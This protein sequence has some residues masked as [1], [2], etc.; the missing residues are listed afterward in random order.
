M[1]QIVFCEASSIQR[2][3]EAVLLN[4]IRNQLD[5]NVEVEKNFID[6]VEGD[7][8]ESSNVE[9]GIDVLACIMAFRKL[10]NHPSLLLDSLNK[11]SKKCGITPTKKVS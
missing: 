5:A 4:W 7:S 6:M 11:H 3:L 1:E 9:S 2:K 10:Y 8:S